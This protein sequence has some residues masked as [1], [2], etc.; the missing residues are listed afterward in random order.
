MNTRALSRAL[1]GLTRSHDRPEEAT[2]GYQEACLRH[3]VRH[4]YAKVPYYRRR[5][6]EAGVDPRDINTLRDLAA[7]PITTRDDIQSQEASDIC[8][9]D[10]DL[11]ALRVI[12]TSGS[13]GAPL[14]VRRSFS[15][16]RLMLAF[17]ARDFTRDGPGW[18]WRRAEID[19]YG[20]ETL[21][22]ERGS[23]LYERL[24]ILPRLSIDWRTPKHELVDALARFQP[25]VVSGPPSTLA[26]IADELTDHDRRRFSLRMVVSGS[27]ILTPHMLERIQRGFGAPVA[28]VYG[29][30]E[31]VFIASRGASR[32]RYSVCRNATIAEVLR[33]GKPVGPGESGEIVVT[34]L[35]LF[36]MPFIRYRLADLVT[37]EAAAGTGE[38]VSSLRSIDG[39]T[40]DRFLLPGGKLFHPYVLS[41]IVQDSGLPVRRFQVIQQRRDAFLVR[42]VLLD[43]SRPNL[44]ALRSQVAAALGPGIEVRAETVATLHAADGSKFKTYLPLERLESW[45]R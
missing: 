7:I 31:T 32:S 4:A 12:K 35:H 39:R 14:T 43:G 9:I 20:Q 30:H 2:L 10:E 1:W 34:A 8:A 6:D 36:A 44:D 28:D 33:D 45:T 11:D 37:V 25:E 38:T 42:V 29:C 21:R 23:S 3:L 18:H 26:W 17:R 41:D 24:G 15:E 19:Y 5:F 13:T 22:P 27:E 40:M 16:E